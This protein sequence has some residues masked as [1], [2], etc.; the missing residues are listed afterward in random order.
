[1]KRYLVIRDY[2]LDSATPAVVGM[3]NNWEDADK[4]AQLYKQAEDKG[5]LY[6]VYEM[7]EK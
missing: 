1:M 6:W 5:Y 7:S 3:F 4:F 2:R